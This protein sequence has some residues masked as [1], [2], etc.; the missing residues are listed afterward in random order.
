MVYLEIQTI[1]FHLVSFPTKLNFLPIRNYNIIHTP[2][3]KTLHIYKM[4]LT[5]ALRKCEK[6]REKDERGREKDMS[7][8]IYDLWEIWNALSNHRAKG[9][10]NMEI[11]HKIFKAYN[12]ICISYNLLS[13]PKWKTISLPYKHFLTYVPR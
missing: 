11:I 4:S 8:T 12:Q 7:H 6:I 13:S 1:A 5:K 9:I 2:D 10:S 3:K